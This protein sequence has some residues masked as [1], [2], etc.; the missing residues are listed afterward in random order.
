MLDGITI[1]ALMRDIIA[2]ESLY[3]Q[4]SWWSGGLKE[5]ELRDAGYGFYRE[6]RWENIVSPIRQ[7]PLSRRL[8]KPSLAYGKFHQ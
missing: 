5:E 2:K 4:G 1:S 6:E 8:V 7:I 3:F